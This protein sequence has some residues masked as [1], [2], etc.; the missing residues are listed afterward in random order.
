MY[1]N[2]DIVIIG[3]GWYGCHI[4][5]KLQDKYKILIVD[6]ANDIFSGSSYY[7]QNRLHLGYHYSR[8]HGTRNLCHEYY[9]NFKNQYSECID[10]IEDNYYAIADSSIICNKTYL[11]IFRHEDFEFLYDRNN[12]NFANI[13]GCPIKVN[14]GV[15]NSERAKCFLKSKLTKCDFIFDTEVINIEHSTNYVTINNKYRCK[16][17]LDCTYNQ[18]NLTNHIYLYELT[19]SLLYKKEKSFGAITVMDG[20]FC[21]L[22]P[23]DGDIYTLTDVEYT[24]LK[25]SN[26]FKEV[27]DYSPSDEK[28][29]ET[30]IK[31]EEKMSYFFPEFL[32]KFKYES[33]F[34]SFKT[35]LI[36]GSDSRNISLTKV[37]DRILSVNCGKIY[38]IFEWEKYV[39]GYLSSI[40]FDKIFE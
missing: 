20:N 13:Q 7:N 17:L 15:I 33:Y 19:L 34:L 24:P 4:A 29:E 37:D 30:R 25:K 12:N 32:D 18:L 40:H 35:K 16:L 27:L 36:S 21:S 22:Y 26:I 39:M 6:K 3:S 5:Y 38:G 28:I 23:R 10:D 9:E 31:M 8:D 2:Y 1:N 11:S 14:E